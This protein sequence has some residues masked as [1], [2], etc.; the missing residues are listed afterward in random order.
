[1]ASAEQPIVFKLPSGNRIEVSSLIVFTSRLVEQKAAESS[2]QPVEV[3]LPAHLQCEEADVRLLNSVLQAV[4]KATLEKSVHDSSFWMSYTWNERVRLE[5]LAVGADNL[6]LIRAANLGA[7]L[8]MPLL[9]HFATQVMASQCKNL[10]LVQLR[11]YLNE[12]DD[13][14]AEKREIMV[15]WIKRLNL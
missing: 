9:L 8:Q 6:A 2:D 14:S 1:M 15:P 3:E 10:P 4:K 7:W 12:P 13:F 11:E 5:P